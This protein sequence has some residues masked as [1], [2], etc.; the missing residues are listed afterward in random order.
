VSTIK[1][2]ARGVTTVREAF[3]EVDALV[4]A[5]KNRADEVLHLVGRELERPDGHRDDGDDDRDDDE[6]GA[7]SGAAKGA[8]TLLATK[9]A[10]SAAGSAARQ[11][12][13]AA[14]DATRKAAKRAAKQAKAARKAG[15]RKASRKAAKKARKAAKRLK[16]QA[17]QTA[18]EL[19]EGA[20]GAAS[21]APDTLH[22]PTAKPR[23]S[24]SRAP[25]VV[26]GMLGAAAVVA[27]LVWRQQQRTRE[28]RAVDNTAPDEFG[29][30]VERAELASTRPPVT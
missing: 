19:V 30:M 15:G 7:L 14:E 4:E 24:R 9:A 21:R 18:S 2:S 28:L 6:S 17:V 5:L 11:V 1:V 29:A 20:K 25:V 16:G 23:R 26:L 8:A 10:T 27:V 12:R 3:D 13:T 22:L